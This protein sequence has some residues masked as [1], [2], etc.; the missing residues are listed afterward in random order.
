METKLEIFLPLLWSCRFNVIV[1]LPEEY[2]FDYDYDYD[3]MMVKTYHEG[4]R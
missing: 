4:I 1:D 2:E 3:M